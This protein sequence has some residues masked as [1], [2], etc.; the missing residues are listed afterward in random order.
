MPDRP[1]PPGSLGVP[2]SVPAVGLDIVVVD[3]G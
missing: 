2:F 3:Y 1:R